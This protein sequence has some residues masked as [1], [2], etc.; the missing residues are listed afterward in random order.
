M[1]AGKRRHER[2]AENGRPS[3][4]FSVNILF[5]LKKRLIFAFEAIT[6][7]RFKPLA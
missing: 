4:A 2:A 5:L 3:R 6:V 7:F 1:R